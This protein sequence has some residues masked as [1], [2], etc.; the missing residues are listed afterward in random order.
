M[1]RPYP[2]AGT[3]LEAPQ[4][5]PLRSAGLIRYLDRLSERRTR[6]DGVLAFH[7]LDVLESLLEAAVQ[8]QPVDV[9]STVERP[10]VVPLGASPDLA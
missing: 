9:G 2:A 5:G 3:A 6:A 10:A 7:V 8:D 4:S 1:L